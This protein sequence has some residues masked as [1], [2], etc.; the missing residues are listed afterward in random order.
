[1][2]RCLSSTHRINVIIAGKQQEL[3]WLNMSG[4]EEHVRRGA[5]VWNWASTSGTEPPDIVLACCGDVPTLETIAAAAI[6][7][8]R[9]PEMKIQVVNV[10]S[11]MCLATE[12]EHAAGLPHEA[13]ITLFGENTPV[14]FNF[15]GYPGVIEDILHRRP[16]PERFYVKGYREEGTTTTPFDMTVLNGISRYHVCMEAVEKNQ[17]MPERH[18]EPLLEMCQLKLQQHHAYIR[19]HLEDMPEIRNW[20]WKY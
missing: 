19:E 15:H 6:L 10:V 11:L 14:I 18:K 13:F 7:R 20:E 17:A 8:E 2:S 12:Q 5:S 1:M 4:A 16:H 3:Q 9:A